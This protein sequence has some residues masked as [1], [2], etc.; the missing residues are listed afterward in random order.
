MV[1]GEPYKIDVKSV[2]KCWKTLFIEYCFNYCFTFSFQL[3]LNDNK[4]DILWAV[5]YTI[6]LSA[7]LYFFVAKSCNQKQKVFVLLLAL[8]CQSSGSP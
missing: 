6:F 7:W 5:A 1:S 3:N 4:Y 2:V 8:G